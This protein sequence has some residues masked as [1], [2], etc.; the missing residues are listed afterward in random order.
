MTIARVFVRINR[1]DI[2]E[3]TSTSICTEIL[4]QK[5]MDKLMKGKTCF[6]IAHR[7]ST[8]V[9]AADDRAVDNGKSSIS[10]RIKS[11]WKRAVFTRSSITVSIRA[12]RSPRRGNEKSGKCQCP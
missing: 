3:A 11:C 7:L 1:F 5:A 2:D 9:N 4:I 6:V 12:Y 8:I 10:E